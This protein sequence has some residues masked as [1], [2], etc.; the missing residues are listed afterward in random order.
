M[1]EIVERA[2]E[3]LCTAFAQHGY[4]PTPIIDLGVLVAN[5]DGTVDEKE[6]AFLREVYEGL[7]ETALPTE[8]VDHLIS[9]SLDVIRSAGT[10]PRQRIVGEILADCDA[11]LPGLT[12]ALAVAF[13]SEG[14]SSA[15]RRVIDGVAEA[16]EVPAEEL[17][18]LVAKVRK[19]SDPDP[20][21]MRN[22]LVGSGPKS[23]R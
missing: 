10:E 1:R 8:V 6:R 12:V 15:E 20:V 11:A 14:L 17:E 9:A 7:L 18:G 23:V 4:N 19:V 5:A 22:I 13:A 16:A 21:S 3:D 2:I